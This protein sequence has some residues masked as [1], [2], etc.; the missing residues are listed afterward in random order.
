ME[1]AQNPS[2]VRSYETPAVTY[3]AILVAHAGLSSVDPGNC[4][5]PAADLLES[6]TGQ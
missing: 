6:L 4:T 2:L 3:E 1:N 5:G